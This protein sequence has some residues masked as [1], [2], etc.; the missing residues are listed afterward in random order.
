MYL[1]EWKD[2]RITSQSGS[3]STL[4]SPDDSFHFSKRTTRK[5]NAYKPESSLQ[6]PKCE[7][8]KK[9]NPIPLHPS[10]KS[11]K[12][13]ASS[14]SQSNQKKSRMSGKDSLH[15]VGKEKIATPLHSA[16]REKFEPKVNLLLSGWCAID[17]ICLSCN[18]ARQ[19]SKMFHLR[20][21]MKS[22]FKIDLTEFQ[23]GTRKPECD[24]RT[25]HQ[26]TFHQ[27]PRGS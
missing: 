15:L 5:N 21:R 26:V 2:I 4:S 25:M 20:P 7:N 17:M 9:T 6:H 22:Y 23:L 18:C 19:L 16:V 3:P 24:Q 11:G 8:R 27:H 12:R 13:K 10:K 14:C 1:C